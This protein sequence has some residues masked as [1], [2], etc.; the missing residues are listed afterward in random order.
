MRIDHKVF[1]QNF[2]K[3]AQRTN[4]DKCAGSRHGGDFEDFER[5]GSRCERFHRFAV[6]YISLRFHSKGDTKEAVVV[7]NECE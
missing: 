5:R 6:F 7:S 2:E 3:D 1:V 4:Y